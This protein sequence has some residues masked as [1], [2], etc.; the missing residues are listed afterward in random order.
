MKVIRLLAIFSLFGVV[1]AGA[2]PGKGVAVTNKNL[3]ADARDSRLAKPIIDENT[4]RAVDLA[5]GQYIQNSYNTISHGYDLGIGSF[6]VW[7]RANAKDDASSKLLESILETIF[8]KSLVLLFPEGGSAIELIKLAGEKAFAGAVALLKKE[9]PDDLDEYLDIYERSTKGYLTE[10]LNMKSNLEKDPQKSRILSDA[11]KEFINYL[12]RQT[13]EPRIIMD[14]PQ[15]VKD[16]LA[17]A[18]IPEPTENTARAIELKILYTSMIKVRQCNRTVVNLF[19]DEALLT[20]WLAEAV[21]VR[22]PLDIDRFCSI[23]KYGLY[24]VRKNSALFSDKICDT[25]NKPLS[26]EDKEILWKSN[27]KIEP[28]SCH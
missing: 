21:L 9:N 4:L 22:N 28:V 25:I 12:D 11:R 8:K 26:A 5:I 15:P 10:L 23:V 20:R 18:G 7:F 14:L 19:E 2:K 16:L 6:R 24:E 1:E 17:K 3:V 13:G 27:I